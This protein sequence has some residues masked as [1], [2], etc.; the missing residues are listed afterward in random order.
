MAARLAGKPP[1]IRP[2]STLTPSASGTDNGTRT[3]FTPTIWKC[4][5]ISPA[6]TPSAPP[7]SDS[8]VASA[9]NCA[10][11]TPGVAPMALRMPISRVRSVT[12]ASM[13]F[14]IPM[15]PTRSEIDAIVPRMMLNRRAVRWAS[16]RSS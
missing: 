7:V 3:G 14:M 9:R 12:V 5:P 6:K 10:R 2:I 15:P 11:I 16:S 8:R 13:M 1:K 4:V